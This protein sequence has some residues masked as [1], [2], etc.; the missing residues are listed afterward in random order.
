MA[1]GDDQLKNVSA[2]QDAVSSA[3]EALKAVNREAKNIDSAFGRVVGQFANINKSAEKFVDLQTEAKKSSE[4]TG[5]AL[6]E[7]TKQKNIAAKLQVK[8]N[9]LASSGEA[10]DRE[11]ALI[12]KSQFDSA[13]ALANA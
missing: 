4:A 13:N 7:Q 1:L 12:L 2:I 6:A 9:S 10:I 3:N 8:I 5:K 11:R